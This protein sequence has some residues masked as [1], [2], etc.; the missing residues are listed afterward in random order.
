MERAS[1][2]LTGRDEDTVDAGPQTTF[3]FQAEADENIRVS[4]DTVQ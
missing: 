2:C 4:D 3:N 1:D